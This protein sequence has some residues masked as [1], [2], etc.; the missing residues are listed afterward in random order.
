MLSLAMLIS[1]LAACGGG[2]GASPASASAS[3]ASTLGTGGTKDGGAAA[4]PSTTAS[5]PTNSAT[6][7][8]AVALSATASMNVD[9]VPEAA[10]PAAPLA[11]PGGRSWYID[12]NTGNDANDGKAATVSGSTGPWRTLARLMQ[13][14]LQPGDTVVLACGSTWGETLRLPASGTATQPIV[15]RAPT[16]GCTTRPAIDGSVTLAATAWTQHSGNIYKAPLDTAPMQLYAS[17]GYL[18]E[19]HHPNKGANTTDPTS[20]YA[21]LAANGNV[22][23]NASGSRGSTTLVT[24]TDLSLPAGA[25]VAPGTRVRVRTFS[26]LMDEGTVASVAGSVLTLQ[27]ATSYPLTAGWGYLLLGQLWM[28]DSAGEWYYDAAAK[29][30]Y[31]WMPDSAKP[32]TVAASVL[33][34]GIDLASRSYVWI[35]GIAVRRVG[36]AVLMRGGQGVKLSNS[37]VEDCTE[38]GADAA[39]SKGASFVSNTFTR[40]GRDAISGQDDTTGPATGMT[41]QNNVIRD[42]GVIMSGDSALSLPKGSHAAIRSGANATVTGNAIVNAGYI[43]IRAGAASVVQNN[44]VYGACSVLDDCGG[45]YTWSD[46]GITIRGNTVVHMRGAAA[47][48]PA[49]ARKTEAQGI[50]LDLSTTGAL[51]VDNTVIDADNGVFIHV[52]SNNTVQGNRL[53]GNRSSQVAMLDTSNLNRSSGDVYGNTV[54]GNQIAAVYPGSVG[55]LLQSMFASTSAFGSFDGNQYYDRTTPIIAAVSSGGTGQVYTLPQWR[56]SSNAGSTTAV[57]SNGTGINGRGY[58]NYSVTGTNAVPNAALLQDTSGWV[59]WSQTAPMAQ[60]VRQTCTAGQ[61]LRFVPGG[62]SGLVASPNFSVLGGQWYRLSVDIAAD[63]NGQSVQIVARRG[64][65]GSNGYESISDR[66][67]AVTAGVSWTRFAMVFQATKT[68]IAG[69]AATGD[70]GARIDIEGL[71]AG[72]SISLANLELVPITPDPSSQLSGVFVNA[73]SSAS[74]AVCPLTGTLAAQCSSFLALADN[75]KVNWPLS[76]PAHSAVIVYAQNPALLDSDGDGI[77]DSQDRCPGTAAGAPVNSSGCSFAQR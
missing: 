3:D 62:S 8:T 54:T 18:T 25:V 70:L 49:G 24:G 68:I 44:L 30:I 64:G 26:W 55:L 19:A 17:S 65:G 10:T 71:V 22:I 40:I 46:A 34:T 50:Y 47:G 32:G 43:G 45:I 69:N 72:K 15:V 33:A 58:S 16:A 76:V 52:A 61:C 53:Y 21:T 2:S 23:T 1:G 4:P 77:P 75:Q 42:S 13:A 31:A 38:M 67:L 60:I 29:Q 74:S 48:K 41:V 66:D 6:V 35:D 39:Y 20:P 12:S 37:V 36:T 56:Q 63:T 5:A 9:G 57:D 27:N 14:T 28:L 7:G 51:V 11:A 59:A 73:G